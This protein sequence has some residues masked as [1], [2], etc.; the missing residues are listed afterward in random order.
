[1]WANQNPNQW[2]TQGVAWKTVLGTQ[3]ASYGGFEWLMEHWFDGTAWSPQS[4]SALN[5]LTQQ[6]LAVANQVPSSVLAGQ[7]SWS[8][9]AMQT[10][11]P[12]PH[13]V[14]LRGRYVAE[15]WNLALEY[16]T[17]P[18]DRG[19]VVTASASW[20]GDRQRWQLGVRRLG[21]DPHSVYAQSPVQQML[22]VYWQLALP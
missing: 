1:V 10:T 20:Q 8:A 15:N 3:W 22:F 2:Q 4:W 12:L 6:Q 16:L 19:Q 13:S 11:N 5:H 9:E 18:Q 14:L 7:L 17:T 21:G